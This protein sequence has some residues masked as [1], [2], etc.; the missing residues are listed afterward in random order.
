MAGSDEESECYES[1][2]RL[3]HDV[4]LPLID[5]AAALAAAVCSVA[6]RLRRAFERPAGSPHRQGDDGAHRSATR[7]A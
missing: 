4:A 6:A 5:S 2:S 3:E 7:S 1:A